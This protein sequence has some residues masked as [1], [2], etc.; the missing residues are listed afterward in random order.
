MISRIHTVIVGAASPEIIEKDVRWINEPLDQELL[1]KVQT[2][3]AGIRDQT[4]M[5]GR[6]EN[7]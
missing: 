2:M 7:N 6:P 4:W 3:M 5:V 1:A